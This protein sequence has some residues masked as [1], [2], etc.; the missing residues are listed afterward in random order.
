[1]PLYIQEKLEKSMWILPPK[2]TRLT[3]GLDCVCCEISESLAL[4]TTSGTAFP[5]DKGQ[6]AYE[7]SQKKAGNPHGVTKTDIGLG[8]VTNAKQIAGLA[9]GTT[10]N[11]VVVWVRTDMQ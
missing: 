8:N 5:G 3:V 9:S 7:H 6:A 2:K 1:M 11:H 4:G 10:A